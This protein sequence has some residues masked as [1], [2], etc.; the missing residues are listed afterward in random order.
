MSTTNEEDV[1]RGT[2]DTGPPPPTPKPIYRP[3]AAQTTL[4]ESPVDIIPKIM[5]DPSLTPEERTA[6]L[7]RYM[8]ARDE[9]NEKTLRARANEMQHA[10][11]RSERQDA[12]LRD[13][14][15]A[16]PFPGNYGMPYPPMA[17][18]MP[19]PGAYPYAPAYASQY[20]N[21]LWSAQGLSDSI[22]SPLTSTISLL[23]VLVRGAVVLFSW[24]VIFY[25]AR[26]L[27]RIVF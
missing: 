20:P 12:I 10:V 23:Q 14:M 4:N 21:S 24:T 18:Q 25:I 5:S 26:F 17:P 1:Y 7:M 13:T 19:Y 15:G 8:N 11:T 9:R 27:Y 2:A 3:R 6:F 22:L 16:S